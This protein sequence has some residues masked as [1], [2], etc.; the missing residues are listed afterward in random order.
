MTRP[1]DDGR[2]MCIAIATISTKRPLEVAQRGERWHL[3]GRAV[4]NGRDCQRPD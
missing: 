3:V 2:A 1:H 4:G